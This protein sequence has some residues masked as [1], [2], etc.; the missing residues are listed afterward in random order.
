[1]NNTV[2]LVLLAISMVTYLSAFWLEYSTNNTYSTPENMRLN[3][4]YTLGIVILLTL[5]KQ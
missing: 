4:I 3:A 2:L 5:I 1:M